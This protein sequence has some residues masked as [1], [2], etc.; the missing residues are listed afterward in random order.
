MCYVLCHRVSL[1]SLVFVMLN[2]YYHLGGARLGSNATGSN[3]SG[4]ASGVSDHAQSL[5]R[6]WPKGLS[7]QT[8]PT[9]R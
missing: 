1:A 5:T 8:Q 9:T 6:G 2:I 7:E 4:S 3:F